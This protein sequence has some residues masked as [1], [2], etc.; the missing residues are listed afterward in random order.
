MKFKR[1]NTGRIYIKEWLKL[2]PYS[3]HSNTDIYYLQLCNSAKKSLL[4]QYK[5]GFDKYLDEK[6][7]NLLSCLLVSYFEDII[8]ET[9]I[10]TAFTNK[11][12]ELYG[13]RLPFYET[14]DYYVNDINIQDVRFLLWYF[15]NTIQDLYF[16]SPYNELIS[17]AAK[18]LMALF[19][20]EYEYAPENNEL[21]KQYSLPE[22]ETDYYICRELINKIL[23]NT[24]LFYP[25]TRFALDK[26]LTDIIKS[27]RND[28]FLTGYLNDAQDALTYSLRTKLLSISGQ[29][30]AAEILGKDHP[31]HKDFLNI[32][33]KITGYFLYKGQDSENLFLEHIASGKRFNLTKKSFE[34]S[35]IPSRV[36]TILYMGIILWRQ[37]WWFSGIHVQIDYNDELVRNQKQSIE[38]KN[39]VE[40][41]DNNED[42]IKETLNLQNEIFL[43]FNNG[44]PIAFLP[45]GEI[46][47]FIQDFINYY[48]ESLTVPENK[49]GKHKKRPD[50]PATTDIEDYEFDE[51]FQTGLVFFNPKSG[52]QIAFDVNSAFPMKENNFFREEKSARDVKSLFFDESISPELAKYCLDNFKDSLPFFKTPEGKIFVEH[53]DFLLRFFKTAN[54]HSKPQINMIDRK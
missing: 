2:K 49:T 45:A 11:H 24:Y 23:F 22:D 47:T 19:E 20:E 5:D 52:I 10:F 37:E 41:L 26:K 1:N 6:E 34:T 16:V 17:I 14:E 27:H 54:Y 33:P 31:L 3:D 51:H 36:D 25:D 39:D 29:E 35:F 12:K 48:Q 8:S 15:I 32:S 38:A 4:A 50:P 9:G 53:P 18:D 7:I 42:K 21:K 28:E 40:F 43:K 44:K 46:D 13:K 30:W